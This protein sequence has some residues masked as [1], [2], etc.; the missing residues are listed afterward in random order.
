ML[1]TPAPDAF[2]DSAFRVGPAADFPT[3]PGEVHRNAELP[4]IM[5]SYNQ[6]RDSEGQITPIPGGHRQHSRTGSFSGSV[7]SGLGVDG[8]SDAASHSS[9]PAAGPSVDRST[10]RRPTL[11]VPKQV[12][13]SPVLSKGASFT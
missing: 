4:Q 1:G 12:Y 3:V 2:D 10:Q 6:P 5:A 11:E 9:E 13:H 7:V 8:V